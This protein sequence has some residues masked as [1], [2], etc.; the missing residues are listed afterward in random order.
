M[1]KVLSF[2][3]R[4]TLFKVFVESQF[5]TACLSGCFT[6]GIITKEIDYRE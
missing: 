2:D 1:S 3:K 4:K 6:V 5:N